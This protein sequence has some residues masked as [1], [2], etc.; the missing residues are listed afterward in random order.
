[1]VEPI[2]IEGQRAWL[3]QYGREAALALGLLN[4]VARRF[5]LDALR[6]PPHRWATPHAKPKP[7]AWGNC[8]RRA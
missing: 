2:V 5:H 7:A 8:R 4:F 6:P 3:K 1:M